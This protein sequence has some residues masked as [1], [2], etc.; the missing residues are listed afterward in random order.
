MFNRLNTPFNMETLHRLFPFLI[1]LPE[2]KRWSVLKADLYAG[3][4][5]SML[6]IP[7]AMAY[8]LLAGLPVY[9]GLYAAFI[10]T[11]IAALFASSRTLSTGPV[12][13]TSLLTA[14]ALQPMA[15]IGTED[16]ITYLMLL[17]FSIGVIQMALGLIR[18]GVVV[19]F[20]SYPVLVG[21]INAVAI[22]IACLQINNLFG[23]YAVTKPHF[24]Q[25]VWQVLEDVFNNPH[26]PTVGIAAIAFLIILVGRKLRPQWPHILFAVAITSLIAWA[27]D[28]EKS[29]IIHLDQVVNPSVQKMLK[30]YQSFPKEMQEKIAEEK[31]F[32][33]TMKEVLSESGV[34]SEK[35]DKAI[36]DAALAKWEVERL[37]TRHNMVLGELSRLVFKKMVTPDGEVVFFVQDQMTPI[38]KVDSAQW[39][40]DEL[41]KEN[42][43]MMQ[44]GGEVVGNV[45]R[46][47]PSFRLVQF[48]WQALSDMFIAALVIALVGFTESITIA[49]RIAAESRQNFDTNQELFSQ[50]ISKF[51]GGFFQCMPVSGSFTRTALNF[52]LGARTPFSSIVAGLIVMIVLL[53]LTP[54]FYYLPYATLGVIIMVGVLSLLDLGEIWRIWRINQNE[55]IIALITFLMALALAPRIA[56][57]VVVG[58][59]LSLGVHLYQ[60]MR[61]RISELSRNEHGQLV[62]MTKTK[63]Y[64]SCYLI[65]LIRLHG[66]MYFANS[67]YFENKILDL[68]QNKQKLRYIILDC[69]SINR[70]DSTGV[71]TLKRISEKLEDAGIEIWFT[72]VRS[73]VLK[74]M[75]RSGFF[76]E[77]GKHHFY[78]DTERA[79]A[80]LSDHLGQKHMKTCPLAK[81]KTKR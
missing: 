3:L 27:F 59:L 6:L 70:L 62:E 66:T 4:I 36:N 15:A 20:V 17:T 79:L 64:E 13:V 80:I 56:Y 10:P 81:P 74:T 32:R 71:K 67:D 16:Y 52:Q 21:L 50:G 30:N 1:W 63:Q 18:F 44:S 51:V 23:V 8:A 49:K 77:L 9:L 58:M 38:G 14:V 22:I 24:Y 33:N 28:Y 29:Q 76:D 57:A 69:F 45:P 65:S 48:S 54:L 5:V 41:P 73:T 11:I 46:G 53:W 72:R 26:W 37:I 47:L 68:V 55:G 12:P 19:N 40:I 2:L 60:S 61:P 31:K 42:Y 39:R 43:L 34:H 7:Q 25:T 35:A 75:V 78:K